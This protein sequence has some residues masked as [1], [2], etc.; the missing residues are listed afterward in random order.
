MKQAYS[1]WVDMENGR[2]KRHL[3]ERF[4][5]SLLLSTS[6]R[7]K[8]AHNIQQAKDQFGTIDDL[9]AVE[10]E[11]MD[12]VALGTCLLINL[13]VQ[14]STAGVSSFSCQKP[15]LN[16]TAQGASSKLH[17]SCSINSSVGASAPGHMLDLQAA[18]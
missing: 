6:H 1:A 18:E 13:E 5:P 10:I 8:A 9:P 14:H 17:P 4:S 11:G 3:S 15:S 2:R 12:D 16:I 7:R